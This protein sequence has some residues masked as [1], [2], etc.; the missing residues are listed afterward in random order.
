MEMTE[1]LQS[2]Q[3]INYTSLPTVPDEKLLTKTAKFFDVAISKEEQDF[4]IG[5]D[6]A[7]V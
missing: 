6:D 2:N 1:K 4:I 3:Y 5:M 7:S